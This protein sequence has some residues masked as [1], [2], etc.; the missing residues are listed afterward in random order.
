[1]SST[2]FAVVATT[3]DSTEGTFETDLHFVDAASA[4]EALRLARERVLRALWPDLESAPYPGDDVALAELREW[5]LHIH[6]L[7]LPSE[8]LGR[9]EQPQ[10]L[11][12]H[13]SASF[14]VL[15]DSPEGTAVPSPYLARVTVTS[16]EGD[17]G[18]V[19]QRIVLAYNPRQ[20]R[21]RARALMLSEAFESHAARHHVQRDGAGPTRAG[22]VTEYFLAHD[23]CVA[24][25]EVCPLAAVQGSE[26]LLRHWY[27][28]AERLAAP[29]SPP[30]EPDPYTSERLSE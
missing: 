20:A 25:L 15:S 26:V 22:S 18:P 19:T 28:R 24:C 12:W 6:L 9:G 14:T 11:T 30:P 16:R 5:G 23:G 21:Q 8:E 10:S 29:S 2:R 13:P 17:T 27:H 3:W 1:M 4:E 7:V